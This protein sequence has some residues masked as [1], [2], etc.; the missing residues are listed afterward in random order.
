MMYCKILF[1]TALSIITLIPN[2]VVMAFVSSPRKATTAPSTITPVRIIS[3][4][5]V[6]MAADDDDGTT[7][8]EE[9]TESTTTTTGAYDV[10]KLVGGQDDDGSGFNQFDPVLSTTGFLSRRFGIVGGLAVFVGLALVEGREIFKGFGDITPL[11]GSGEWTTQPSGLRIKELLIGKAG[12][13]PLPG[14]IIG[15]RAVVKIGDRTIY[16]TAAGEKPVAFK[17]GQRPFQNVICDGV[18]E[19]IEG[20][21]VGGKRI[22]DVPSNLAPPGVELPPGV[23]L[24]YEIELTEVLSGYF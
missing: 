8:P 3:T 20:M 21:K 16:E 18:E 2:G 7:K 12:G 17:F 1:V 13:V 6:P 5:A 10:S 22:L 23:P 24:T 15:L 11:E 9:S 19:G 14:Y 4:I